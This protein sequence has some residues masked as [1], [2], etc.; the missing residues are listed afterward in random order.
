MI[1]SKELYEVVNRR[2]VQFDCLVTPMGKALSRI[3]L[4]GAA[5]RR[6]TSAADF[7]L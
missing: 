2:A 6:F 3:I 5:L 7:C 1:L 4:I